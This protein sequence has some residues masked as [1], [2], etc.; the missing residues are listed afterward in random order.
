VHQPKHSNSKLSAHE[1][2]K[3]DHGRRGGTKPVRPA[4]LVLSQ[5]DQP[6]IHYLVR[7][8]AQAGVIHVIL[9]GNLDLKFEVNWLKQTVMRYIAAQNCC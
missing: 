9:Y 3:C 8:I 1:L 4:K 5:Y 7:Q 2:G 6:Q